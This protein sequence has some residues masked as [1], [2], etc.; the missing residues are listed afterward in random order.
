MV[1]MDLNQFIAKTQHTHV[2]KH[3]ICDVT[4]K[5]CMAKHSKCVG[6]CEEIL[7]KYYVYQEQIVELT[8]C[9]EQNVC[10]KCTVNNCQIFADGNFVDCMKVVK[11]FFEGEK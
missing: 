8:E 7:K 9:A 11:T 1:I 6:D 2:G 5:M 10:K 4:G 3:L